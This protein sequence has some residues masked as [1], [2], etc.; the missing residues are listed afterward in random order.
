MSN[1]LSLNKKLYTGFS[2]VLGLLILTG[3]LSYSALDNAS[4][5][6]ASYREMARDTNLTGR[7]Q[8]NMLMVRMNVKDFIITAS[9]KDKQQFEGYWLKT[10]EFMKEAQKEI[11]DP[12]RAKIIDDVD[13]YLLEYHKGF[14]SVVE[15]TNQR[16][17]I[18]KTVMDIQG[19]QIEKQLTAILTSAKNDNDMVTA[20]NASHATRSFLLARIYA[21]KFLDTNQAIAMDRVRSELSDMSKYLDHLDGELQ[22][23]Q[24][25][26]LLAAV[27]ANKEVYLEEINKVAEVI[28]ARNKIITQTL[29]RLGPLVAKGV[30]DVKLEIK[31]VQDQLGPELQASNSSSINTIIIVLFIA[32]VFGVWVAFIITRTTM[33]QL[34]DDPLVVTDI[35]KRVASG[36]LSVVMNNKVNDASLYGAMKAMIASLSYKA[37]LTEKISQGDLSQTV[38]LSSEKDSLG[39]SLQVMNEKLNNVLTE[40][41]QSGDQIAAGSYQVSTSSQSLAEGAN[42]QATSIESISVAL[43]ELSSQSSTNAEN[44]TMASNLADDAKDSIVKGQE[45]MAEMITAMHE[46]KESGNSISEFISTIDAIAEQTNLLALNAAIEAARAGE[47]GRGF[48]VVADEVRNLAARTTQAAVETTKLIHQSNKNTEHGV[49]IAKSTAD[50]LKSVHGSIDNTLDLVTLIAKANEEQTTALEGVNQGIANIEHIT[51]ENVK[52]SEGGAAAAEELSS[53]AESLK[54]IMRHFTLH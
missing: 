11:N 2:I 16:N 19:P 28:F 49:S 17:T 14:E 47:Q 32:L 15:L 5:G 41:Q 30:E 24:R 23:P 20:Y 54:N 45:Y 38:T 40:V 33:A 50:A 43:V 1:E 35:V 34:G 48:A 52:A 44:A 22:K 4:V 7:V 13:A 51:Q 53:Q 6:F 39:A 21:G 10:K 8:A 46:I 18:V 9:D 36:D 26:E 25:R 42:E 31:G 29:D 27:I 3:G 37:E 12:N